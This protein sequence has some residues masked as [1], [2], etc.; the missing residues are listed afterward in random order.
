MG[1]IRNGA[2]TFLTIISH[3]C[4]LSHLPG[5]VTGLRNILGTEGADNLYALWTPLCS[6]V[7]VLIASDNYFNKVD[8]V[9]EPGDSE[10][11]GGI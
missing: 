5:F 4:K 6:L 7:E 11:Q 1:N 2:R 10:D 8:M 9:D 3:A